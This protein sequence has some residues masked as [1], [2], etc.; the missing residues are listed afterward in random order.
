L[1]V[2]SGF[3][4]WVFRPSSLR[5]VPIVLEGVVDLGFVTTAFFFVAASADEMLGNI[6]PTNA[7]GNVATAPTAR[8]V[9][10]ADVSKS[11]SQWLHNRSNF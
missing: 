6:E 8:L 9:F 11:G 3:G 4:D 5:L 10:F 2:I 7:I 1:G